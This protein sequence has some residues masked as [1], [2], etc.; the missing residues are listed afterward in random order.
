[1]K[2]FLKFV[3]GM[4]VGGG[5]ALLLAP[6]SGV[7]VRDDIRKQYD[8]TKTEV[9]TRAHDARVKLDETAIAARE[10]IEAQR[11][12]VI[13]AV[14]KLRDTKSEPKMALKNEKAEEP[15]TA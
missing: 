3:A 11:A 12:R 9:E 5:L 1:M 6:K 8:T 15:V 7:E 13:E 14:Q 4:A 2:G 10:S